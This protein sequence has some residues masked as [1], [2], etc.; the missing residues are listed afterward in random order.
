MSEAFLQGRD[1]N[2]GGISYSPMVFTITATSYYNISVD[3]SCIQPFY[4]MYQNTTDT[5]VTDFRYVDTFNVGDPNPS[6]YA[7]GYGIIKVGNFIVLIVACQYQGA[8]Y[9]R[10][11]YVHKLSDTGIFTIYSEVLS[12]GESI[13]VTTYVPTLN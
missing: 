11:V 1:F 2:S 6:L 7:T 12:S 9:Q 8:S 10:D 3:V 5:G 13:S 4:A